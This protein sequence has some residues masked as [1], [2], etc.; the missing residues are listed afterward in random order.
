MSSD[1]DIEQ[2]A[3]QSDDNFN[4]GAYAAAEQQ[5]LRLIDLDAVTPLQLNN[6]ALIKMRSG[7]TQ[8]AYRLIKQAVRIAPNDVRLLNNF[9]QIVLRQIPT[10]RSRQVALSALRRAVKL[11]RKFAHAWFN[12]GVIYMNSGDFANAIENF[13]TTLKIDPQYFNALLNLV[14]VLIQ[15]KKYNQAVRAVT[16]LLEQTKYEVGCYG[17]LASIYVDLYDLPAAKHCVIMA[18]SIEVGDSHVEFAKGQLYTASRQMINA[19][20]S[21]KLA[22]IKDPRNFEYMA[23]LAAAYLLSG[24][25]REG[26]QLYEKRWRTRRLT[27]VWRRFDDRVLWRGEAL[28]QQTILIILEQGSGDR[29]QFIRLAQ[30]LKLR[31]AHVIVE[32]MPRLQR[33]F[34]SVSAGLDIVSDGDATMTEFYCPAMSIPFGM[35]LFTKQAICETWRGP[36]IKAEDDGIAHWSAKLDT[37]ANTKPF[38]VVINWQGNVNFGRD[39][40]RSIPLQHFLCLE[41]H[42]QL[43]S[44]QF[45]DGREQLA[46]LGEHTILDIGTELDQGEHGFVDTAAVMCC[47]DLVIT[48]DTA[49]AHLAGALGRPVWLL[50]AYVPEWRWGLTGSSSPWYP[51]MTLFRQ[52]NPGDWA[53]VFSRVA[54]ELQRIQ[55]RSIGP[56]ERKQIG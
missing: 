49:V 5:Y 53:E 48:S 15:N 27:P 12:L 21:Y 51:T 55:R 3:Q 11:D 34:T 1:D 26:F 13:E 35:G 50:L 45:K 32:I 24:H 19:L 4:R 6:L 40:Q 2:L 42:A 25:F 47:A 7:D 30:Q 31:G 22:L 41:Q 39:R 28:N 16:D 36:Y 56:A 37:T 14:F 29:I 44:I 17:L 33:V 52:T 9:S 23:M 43:I 10:D 20:N 54:A 8:T 38:R 18:E 46:D